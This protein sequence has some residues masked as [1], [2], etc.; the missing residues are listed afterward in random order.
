MSGVAVISYLLRNNGGVTAI[1][2]NVVPPRIVP[3]DFP[4][5]TVLPAI[6]IRQISS[7]PRLTL[8]MSELPRMHTDRVMVSVMLKGPNGSPAGLGYPGLRSLLA[9]VLAACPNQRGTVN[10]ITVDSI[11]PD[12]E[13]PDDQ[14]P[15]TDL[16]TGSR[17][18]FVKWISAT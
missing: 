8:R 2:P 10:G 16:Y 6:S 11:L 17:D 1:V 9:L 5:N 3:G 4:L 12:I 13:S 18:F 14:L 7:V 15:E